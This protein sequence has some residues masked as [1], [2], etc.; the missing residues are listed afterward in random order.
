MTLKYNKSYNVSTLASKIQ[1]LDISLQ[2][3]AQRGYAPSNTSSDKSDHHNRFYLHWTCSS[4]EKE[5]MSALD[6][7]QKI[8]E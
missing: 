2:N 6:D 7:Q 3:T 8:Q 5:K 4:E 1:Y